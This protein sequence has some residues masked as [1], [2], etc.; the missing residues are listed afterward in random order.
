[1]R[2]K[3]NERPL[4]VRVAELAGRQHGVVARGQLRA[5]GFGP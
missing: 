4:D 5:I 3:R 1:M 2:G